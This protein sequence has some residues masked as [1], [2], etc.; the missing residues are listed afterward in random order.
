MRK[1]VGDLYYRP[2]DFEMLDLSFYEKCFL[3]IVLSEKTTKYTN[4]A[5]GDFFGLN[6]FVI[7]RMISKLHKQHYI[8]IKGKGRNRQIR[9]GARF[10]E[11]KFGK[12]KLEN[13]QI[14]NPNIF[15]NYYWIKKEEK[16]GW[17]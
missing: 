12:E 6:K 13:N 8:R 9:I 5:L 10:Y 2:E 4:Q 17:I 7:S 3:S 16:D 14:L 15:A 11:D 1:E